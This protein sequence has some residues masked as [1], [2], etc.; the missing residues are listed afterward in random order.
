[1]AITKTQQPYEFL[2]RWR[3]GVLAGAHIQLLTKVVD[4]D[5]TT[6]VEKLEPAMKVSLAGEAGFPLADVL[7][8][9]QISALADNEV[10]AAHIAALTTEK[11]ELAASVEVLAKEKTALVAQVTTLTNEK[12]ELEQQVGLLTKVAPLTPG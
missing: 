11:S 4:D 5:G 6:L 2:A 1:M 9:L 8:A 12:A 3:N 7:T 10:K